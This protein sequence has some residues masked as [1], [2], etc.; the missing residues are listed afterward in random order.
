MTKVLRRAEKER[1]V[2]EEGLRACRLA[3]PCPKEETYS[4]LRDTAKFVQLIAR[5]TFAYGVALD[6]AEGKET[7]KA[8]WSTARYYAGLLREHVENQRENFKGKKQ[9]YLEIYSSY[10]DTY[11]VVELIAESEK[12]IPDFENFERIA[13]ELADVEQFLAARIRGFADD[14]LA[15]S[16][17]VPGIRASLRSVR[18]HKN[19]AKALIA[20]R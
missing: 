14:D 18:A 15:K 6:V 13:K 9:D 16:P 4:R 10:I 5:N 19:A 2:L 7:A 8:E 12:E 20:A 3:D 17:E 1:Q 11:L